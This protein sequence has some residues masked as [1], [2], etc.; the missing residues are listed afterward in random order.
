MHTNM[1]TEVSDHPNPIN[2]LDPSQYHP[3]R[4][5]QMLHLPALASFHKSYKDACNTTATVS[6]LAAIN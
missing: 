4:D 1:G 3:C 5:R 2:P 6:S